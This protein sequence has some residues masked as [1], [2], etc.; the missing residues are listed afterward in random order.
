MIA[1]AE[2]THSHLLV[3]Q[4]N[5]LYVSSIQYLLNNPGSPSRAQEAFDLT[6]RLSKSGLA[7][8]V[9]ENGES[10]KLWLEVADKLLEEYLTQPED[11]HFAKEIISRDL[12]DAQEAIGWMRHAFIL[13]FF[14]LRLYT[15][16]L[17]AK[18]D[19]NEFYHYSLKTTI[20]LGGDTDTN[21]CIVGGMIGAL[22]GVKAIPSYMLQTL[23]SFD[24]THPENGH[25]RPEFLSV[26][27]HCV[28]SIL[29]LIE[30]RPSTLILK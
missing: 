17:G 13:S 6:Y 29:R 20:Q 1:D 18:K 3:H 24:C 21:A 8:F 22:V 9:D 11:L 27:K 12:L 28:P 4:T 10:C 7:D 19:V 14:Y 26:Q 23:F 2:F 16:L 30:I 15:H 25:K 5:F